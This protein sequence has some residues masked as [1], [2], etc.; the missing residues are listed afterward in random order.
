MYRMMPILILS[1]I[2]SWGCSS[3]KKTSISGVW[4]DSTH[5]NS[6]MEFKD[7]GALIFHGQSDGEIVKCDPE[8]IGIS[9]PLE[10]E[11][12]FNELTGEIDIS[13]SRFK[14]L[15]SALE[16]EGS[17]ELI[18]DS[19]IILSLNLSNEIL[20]WTN[21]FLRISEDQI[22]LIGEKETSILNRSK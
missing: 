14:P 7:D 20:T 13:D 19:K 11:G 6:I 8:K 9:A 16:I 12:T 1:T 18:N 10:V 3:P 4:I 15:G 22:K 17:W 2:L 5:T 21:R